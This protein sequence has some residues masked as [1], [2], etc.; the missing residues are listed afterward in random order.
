MPFVKPMLKILKDI[1]FE[2]KGMTGTIS[3]KA[4]DAL[5]PL[6]MF[7]M[8]FLARSSATVREVRQVR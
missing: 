5:V 4:D 3:L 8:L 6:M 7:P 2:A 1:K